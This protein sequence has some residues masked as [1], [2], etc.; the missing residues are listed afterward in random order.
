MKPFFGVLLWTL[1]L[2]VV[3]PSHAALAGDAKTGHYGRVGPLPT[4]ITSDARALKTLEGLPE[5]YS[6]TLEVG[7]ASLFFWFVRA[8]GETAKASEAPIIV[9]RAGGPGCSALGMGGL[10]DGSGPISLRDDKTG[11]VLVMPNKFS[12]HHF[13]NVLY[14]EAPQ[15]V[16]FSGPDPEEGESLHINDDSLLVADFLA[17]F[18][19]E[20]SFKDLQGEIVLAGE[21]FAGK[22]QS[23]LAG[24]LVSKKLKTEHKEVAD[25]VM[26]AALLTP[27]LNVQF[28]YDSSLGYLESRNLLDEKTGDEILE[29]CHYASLSAVSN[30]AD[31]PAKVAQFRSPK[32]CFDALFP[33]SGPSFE[34]SFDLTPRLG[35]NPFGIFL[36]TA[37]VRAALHVPETAG[38]WTMCS[39]SVNSQTNEKSSNRGAPGQMA[40]FIRQKRKILVVAGDTDTVKNPHA[41]AKAVSMVSKTTSALGHLRALESNDAAVQNRLFGYIQTSQDGLLSFAS[42]ADAGHLPAFYRP[43][44]TFLLMR[45][46]VTDCMPA[47]EKVSPRLGVT[48]HM[49]AAPVLGAAA[50]VSMDY[51]AALSYPLIPVPPDVSSPD[52]PAP[53]AWNSDDCS[54]ASHTAPAWK[55]FGVAA[56]AKDRRKERGGIRVRKQT[57]GVKVGPKPKKVLTRWASQMKESPQKKR[58]PPVKIEGHASEPPKTPSQHSH[59]EATTTTFKSAQSKERQDHRLASKPDPSEESDSS[60]P[61]SGSPGIKGL[62]DFYNHMQDETPETPP[63]TPDALDEKALSVPHTVLDS[64]DEGRK[65]KAD[66]TEIGSVQTDGS[67][68][69]PPPVSQPAVEE[70]T[71]SGESRGPVLEEDSEGND[72]P[73]S[74]LRPQPEPQSQSQATAATP[75]LDSVTNTEEKPEEDEPVNV[76]A[77]GRSE[78]SEGVSLET[79]VTDEETS[80]KQKTSP[81]GEAPA[82]DPPKR[83]HLNGVFSLIFG[84]KSR[85]K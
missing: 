82:T 70:A 38:V 9:W 76:T 19:Q 22:Y 48:T 81:R 34:N 39:A 79:T 83:K 27:D 68:S 55:R 11:G 71:T 10:L 46:F 24:Y 51:G 84:R 15:G 25:R 40:S 18:L 35:L 13:A 37:E 45:A 47:I 7:G 5:M 23:Y 31:S 43:A 1:C 36:N 42:L 53:A 49:E 77:G 21:S 56:S 60:S 6:G 61:L 32:K 44:E 4:R 80:E 12:W 59:S 57:V 20:E 66:P 52:P 75:D 72:L 14:V 85:Q 8:S 64:P 78:G 69:L 73:E 17:Q 30:S 65:T 16:G 74:E 67:L 50:T 2:V 26:K 58:P 29:S 63:N 54:A 41:V 28:D 33:E 3:L 62:I